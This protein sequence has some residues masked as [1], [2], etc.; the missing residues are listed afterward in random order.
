[1]A[2]H[3][4]IAYRQRCEASHIQWLRD[5][6]PAE[7]LRLYQGLHRLAMSQCDD[8]PGWQRLE[9][10]RWREK[11]AIRRKLHEAFAALDASNGS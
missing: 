11:V 10:Q 6:T 9:Q 5:L 7:S 4:W 3:D 1:M 2:E 8:S